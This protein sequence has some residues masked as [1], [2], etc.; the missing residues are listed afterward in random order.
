M[1]VHKKALGPD[2]F[3]GEFLSIKPILSILFKPSLDIKN[4]QTKPLLT[5]SVKLPQTHIPN[6]TCWVLRVTSV[7]PRITFR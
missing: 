7:F 1:Y 3:M 5:C 6:A 2:H 4:K